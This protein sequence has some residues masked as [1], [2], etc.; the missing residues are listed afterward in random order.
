MPSPERL[1]LTGNRLF[2]L[3]AIAGSLGAF[4]SYKILSGWLS[5]IFPMPMMLAGLV[6]GALSG[7]GITSIA[8]EHRRLRWIALAAALFIGMWVAFLSYLILSFLAGPT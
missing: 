5:L 1:V 3:G 4:L 7:I 8:D 2:F 6:I